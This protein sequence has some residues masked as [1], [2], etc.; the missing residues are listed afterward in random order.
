M[1]QRRSNVTDV[2]NQKILIKKPAELKIYILSN[3]R[4]LHSTERLFDEGKNRGHAMYVYPPLSLTML[5]EKGKNDLY[6][7]SRKISLPNMII[8]RVGQNKPA[9][10]LAVVRQFEMLGVPSLNTS[11]AITRSRD[12]LRSLQILSQN[13]IAV[14]RT[15]FL[16]AH[17]D[18]ELALERVGGTPVIIKVPEGTQ[19]MGVILAESFRSAKSILDSMLNAGKHVLVQEFISESKNSD[20]RA[21]VVDGRV[22]AAMRRTSVGEEF[23]S[24]VHRG[25]THEA[26]QLPVEAEIT[27]RNAAEAL[28]LQLAGV[29]LIESHR[30]YLVL[31]VNSSPGLTGIEAATQINVAEKIIQQAERLSRSKPKL[32]QIGF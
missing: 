22:V 5:V 10:T 9:Y 27:A 2:M 12:K 32:D 19:G 7:Q 26:V 4:N 16:D 23:R 6:F 30:G 24:N 31:E 13:S 1:W 20:L 29:D 28:G 8:P 18:I 15:F 25:G 17:R 14:P 21:I 3:S 11:L